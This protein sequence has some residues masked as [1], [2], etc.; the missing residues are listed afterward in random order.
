MHAEEHYSWETFDQFINSLFGEDTCKNGR[1]SN[2]H[3][4]GPQG[5]QLVADYMSKAAS[6]SWLIWDAALPKYKCIHDELQFL[7]SNDK[8]DYHPPKHAPQN[9]SDNDV[10]LDILDSDGNEIVDSDTDLMAVL[11]VRRAKG[12][13]HMQAQ[14]H[15]E[16]R[17]K[18]RKRPNKL[19][20][21]NGSKQ[22]SGPTLSYSDVEEIINDGQH[23]GNRHGPV[24]KSIAWFHDAVLV[25]TDDGE[26]IWKFVCQHCGRTC[27]L[28]HTLKGPNPN[29]SDEEHLP[30]MTNI[31]GHPAKCSQKLDKNSENDAE[32]MNPGLADKL[33]LV[34]SRKLM[35]SW[36]KEGNLDP[37]AI[38]T[39]KGFLWLFAV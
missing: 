20:R 36:L 17:K 27:K 11:K 35:E 34:Q 30:S 37:D 1:L 6:A 24:N 28:P 32:K 15:E 13:A 5:M 14:M 23:T 9:N 7:L 38:V 19:K 21:G 10:T 3:F 18:M 4:R 29:F 33:N 12:A 31:A 22:T 25:M 39:R 16:M 26:M 2:A 8:Q